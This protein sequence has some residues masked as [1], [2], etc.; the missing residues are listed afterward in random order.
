VRA[1]GTASLGRRL[2]RLLGVRAAGAVAA[3]LAAG[4]YFIARGAGSRTLL[5]LVY[6]TAV[7]IAG[8]WLIGRHRPGLGAERSQVPRRV[9]ER[10]P[11]DVELTLH[12][13]R[14]VS[15]VILEEELHPRLGGD[16]RVPLP[17]MHAGGDLRHVYTFIPRL[18]GVYHVGPLIATWS[19]PFGL[20]SHHLRLI[21]PAE[22][23]VHPT[24]E[25][26]QDRVI[27]REWEDPPIRPPF[28]KPWPTGFEFYGMREYV[29]GDDPRRIVWRAVARA[30]ED[31]G[32]VR[33]LVREAE[34]GITDRVSIVLDTD[35][36]RHSP[37]DPSETFE[38][39]IRVVASLGARHLED[40]FAVTLDTNTGRVVE[41][42]RGRAKRV[43]FLDLLARLQ[44]ST[45][46]LRVAAD[47][48]LV[49]GRRDYHTVLVTPY[50]DDDVAARLRLI[51]QRGVSLLIALVVTDDSDPLSVHRAGALGCNV[52]EVFPGIPLA[53]SFR[54][55]MSGSRRR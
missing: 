11:V 42:L 28:S 5:L 30:S 41:A 7:V 52:V 48:L 49:S 14:R 37:G 34:Q 18:R 53:Q 22:I 1:S 4:A 16:V 55:V 27:T 20:T 26:V 19:D 35:R 24:V 39:A 50:L 8:S 33:L 46:S 21:E 3:V 44:P 54:R 31:E 17:L 9:R 29:P 47:R 25:S 43:P 6:G 36:R 10:Q 12:A 45:E 23:I 32:N 51:V 13:R 15:T 2:E 40:G 38:S